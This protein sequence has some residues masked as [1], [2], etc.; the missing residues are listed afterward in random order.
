MY[1]IN[2]HETKTST[3]TIMSTRKE[4]TKIIQQ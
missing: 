3:V 1:I 2:R 4:L